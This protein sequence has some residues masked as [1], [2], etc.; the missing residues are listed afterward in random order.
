MRPPFPAPRPW[1][2]APARQTAVGKEEED[3]VDEKL[4]GKGR[5]APLRAWRGDKMKKAKRQN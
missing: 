5:V 3:E 4:D 2:G 1:P